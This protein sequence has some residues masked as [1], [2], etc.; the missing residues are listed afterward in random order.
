MFLSS[1]CAYPRMA[2]QP[3]REEV[4]L[5]GPLEPTNQWYAVAK[6]AGIM[7]GQAFRQQ[8]GADIIAAMPTNLYGQHDN[9]DLLSSHVVP[10]LI[11]K[12]HMAKEQRAASLDVW[13]TGRAI[14]EFLYVDDAADGMVFL[15]K[16][17]S[18]EGIVNL[19]TGEGI[20]IA[21]LAASVCRVVGFSG[22]IRY[23]ST[24]PDGTPCKIV[25]VS[26]LHALGW[27]HRTALDTGIEQTYRWY[28]DHLAD[29]G[30]AR[31]AHG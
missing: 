28:V 10:A 30:H 31:L 20:T 16:H 4:L 13:G 3:M 12:A 15:M 6:I 14:R 1:S 2:P 8:Y 26:R 17:Y 19:G 5:T 9:F 23:D 22:D 18:E 7:L 29:R 27:R 24:K 21:E 11:A 25:D